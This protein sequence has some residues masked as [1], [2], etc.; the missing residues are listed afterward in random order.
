MF[1]KK[2]KVAQDDLKK[3]KKFRKNTSHVGLF[4]YFIM[5]AMAPSARIWTSR[6]DAIDSGKK[7]SGM[8]RSEGLLL[9]FLKTK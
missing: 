2:S 9:M 7:S 5:T 3:K 6:L 1:E 8:I 4:K